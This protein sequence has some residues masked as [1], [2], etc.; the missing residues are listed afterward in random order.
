[1]TR[2]ALFG[3]LLFAP[4]AFAQDEVDPESGRTIK[5]KEETS[6][7]FD[8]VDVTGELVKPQGAL[9]SERRRASFNP[10][11]QLRTDFNEEMRQSVDE[12]K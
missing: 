3:F 9:V 10:L 8:E 5:Y 4:K 1:M 11:I 7:D 6:I 2:I 12:V